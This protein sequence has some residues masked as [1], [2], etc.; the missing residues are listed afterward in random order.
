MRNDTT[1]YACAADGFDEFDE[2][3]SLL[4]SKHGVLVGKSNGAIGVH[5][6]RQPIILH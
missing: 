5:H 2:N 4:G 3:F 1:R 6:N